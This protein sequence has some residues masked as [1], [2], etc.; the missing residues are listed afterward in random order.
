MVSLGAASTQAACE[1]T[2]G[3][4]WGCLWTRRLVGR[5]EVMHLASP[6]QGK[7]LAGAAVPRASW[8]FCDLR[9]EDQG[10]HLGLSLDLV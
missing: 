1:Y 10:S 7:S 9:V 5:E 6:D 2:V 3:T 8:D 4:P